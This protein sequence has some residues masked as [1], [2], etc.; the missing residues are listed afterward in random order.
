M[1]T[2]QFF[3][4]TLL[5]LIMLFFGGLSTLNAQSSLTLPPHAS[6]YSF[7][8]RGYWFTAPRDFIITGLRVPSEAGSGTQNIQVIKITG[9][10]VEYSATGSNFT[11]LSYIKGAPN[12]V[13]QTVNIYV[14]AGDQIGVL[15]EAG[16]NTSYSGAVTPYASSIFGMPITIGRLVYQNHIDVNQAPNYSIETSGQ[17]GRVEMYYSCIAPSADNI[18]AE[19][20]SPCVFNFNLTNA[21]KATSYKWDFGD[22][23]PVANGSTTAHAYAASG[24]YVVKAVLIND[25]DSATILKAV[26]CATTGVGNSLIGKDNVKIYPN[27]A[28]DLVTIKAENDFNLKEISIYN[29][30]GQMVYQT[31]AKNKNQHVLNVAQWSSGIYSVYIQTNKETVVK[32]LQIQR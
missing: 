17:I 14:S 15:G 6:V 11:T 29:L 9:T 2:I 23:S 16:T 5:V 30:L 24:S 20:V 8:V 13:I 19:Q 18:V 27:P 25:C 7:T 31:D 4:S 28:A 10:P 32:K 22:G 12:G 26:T 1:K 21:Q 3:K